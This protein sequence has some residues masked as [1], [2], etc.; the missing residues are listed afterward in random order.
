MYVKSC[1]ETTLKAYKLATTFKYHKGIHI[2]RGTYLFWGQ[3]F[4]PQPRHGVSS[5]SP[6]SVAAF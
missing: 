4:S 3:V 5:V 1:I 2:N 6:F